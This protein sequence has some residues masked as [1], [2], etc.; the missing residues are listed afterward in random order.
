MFN[1]S[2][3]AVYNTSIDITC[4]AIDDNGDKWLGTYKGGLIK[5]D[6]SNWTVYNVA[7]SGL[8]HNDVRC[9]T[10][11]QDDNKWIGTSGGNLTMFDGS[12]WTLY[13]ISNTDINYNCIVI[14][15]S[16]NKWIG[17]YEGGLI[18]Y[19]QGG[20]VSVDG[21]MNKS[22][23]LPVKSIL[24]QN[25]PNPFNPTTTIE[26]DLPKASDVRIEVYNIAGQKI[27][28]LLNE[29]MPPGNHQVEFDAENLSSGVYCYRIELKDPARRTDAFQDVKKMILIK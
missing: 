1:G 27:Q 26:F 24:S 11:D 17:T 5:F 19:N 18:V 4:I 25:Y 23:L 7:N 20:I 2:D 13:G 28:T 10:I 8:P 14:D 22:K 21:N 3:W 29:K 16:G 15:K 12:D 9:I 6:G